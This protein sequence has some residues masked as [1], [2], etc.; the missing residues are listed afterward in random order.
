M[1]EKDIIQ[2]CIQH[3]RK[4]QN[5]LYKLYFPLMSNIALRYNLNKDDALSDINYGFFKVLQNL[6]HY[7][8][9]FAL[10]TYIR[11]ILIRHII[12][13][14]RVSKQFKH[15]T[16][17]LNSVDI[18]HN[19][20]TNLGSEKLEFED[21]MNL[22]KKLPKTSRTVFLMFA[23]DGFKHKEIAEMLNIS[24]GTSKWHVNEARKLLMNM[25][26]N[27]ENIEIKLKLQMI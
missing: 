22:L 7:N 12:D 15:E 25:L 26:N 24:E 19:Y 4:C 3:D 2:G 21:L 23:I 20:D 18:Q 11:T 5:I 9:E 1:E 16:L 6:H 17:D 10:A 13:K 27:I 14:Q 8:P